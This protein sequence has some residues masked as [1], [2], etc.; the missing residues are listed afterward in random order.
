MNPVLVTTI[1]L[2]LVTFPEIQDDSNR[3]Q[4]TLF[5]WATEVIMINIFLSRSIM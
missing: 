4:V 2:L 3:A 1:D 5:P